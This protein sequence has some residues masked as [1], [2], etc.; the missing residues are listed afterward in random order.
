MVKL[1][2]IVVSASSVS[3]KP[4][5]VYIMC[6]NCR[7]HMELPIH[8]YASFTLP[9]SC[10]Q[11][12]HFCEKKVCDP[13]FAFRSGAAAIT[14]QACPV[15]PFVVLPDKTQFVDVQTLKLQESPDS[16]PVG[17]LPRHVVI[18]VDR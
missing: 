6:R 3:S 7:N 5:R 4:T 17:E 13:F 9:R 8:E 14:G 10:P 11:Y 15:D 1:S 16:V 18:T 12:V 2:G